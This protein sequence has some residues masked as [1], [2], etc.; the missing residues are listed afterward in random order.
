VPEILWRVRGVTAE[1]TTL[2][3]VTGYLD[4]LREVGWIE[5]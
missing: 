4:V 1:P 2:A 5:M 3:Q